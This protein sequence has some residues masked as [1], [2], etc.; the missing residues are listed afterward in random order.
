MVNEE[1][2]GYIRG[3]LAAGRSE[4][5]ITQAL[6]DYGWGQDDIK[7][8]LLQAKGVPAGQ[9]DAMATAQVAQ[10]QPVEAAVA[11][12]PAAAVEPVTQA[13]QVAQVQ[14]AEPVIQQQPVAQAAQAMEQSQP[15]Q[16][17]PQVVQQEQQG[18]P[19]DDDDKKRRMV[20]KGVII[21]ILI[22][23][24]FWLY[25]FLQQE[26]APVVVEEEVVTTEVKKVTKKEVVEEPKA[27]EKEVEK[28]EPLP[29]K[30]SQADIK[31]LTAKDFSGQAPAI[32]PGKVMVD[33]VLKGSEQ[34]RV[35]NIVRNDYTRREIYKV[36]IHG[37]SADY[38]RGD[39]LLILDAGNRVTP[40]EFKILPGEAANGEYQAQIDFHPYIEDSGAIGGGSGNAVLA[41]VAGRIEFSV[42]GEERI[43]FDIKRTKVSNTEVGMGLP[44]EYQVEN[45][46]NVNWRPDAINA[47]VY[48]VRGELAQKISV[49]AEELEFLKPGGVRS[50]KVFMTHSISPGEYTLMVE[51]EFR[52][53]KVAQSEVLPLKVFPQNTIGQKGELVDVILN[54]EVY[55]PGETARVEVEFKNTGEVPVKALA[56]GELWL[57]DSLMDTAR[58]RELVIG[59]GETL[60]LRLTSTFEKKGEYSLDVYVEYGN[61]VSDTMNIMVPVGVKAG[62]SEAT[63]DS[64]VAT[65]VQ[66]TGV[67][68]ALTSAGGIVGVS[69]FVLI[70]IL[71]T[72]M[73]G[74]KK[75]QG[76]QE[77]Q[78][79]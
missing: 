45:T 43:E 22:L 21:L 9:A 78:G 58:G 16:A 68:N 50:E 49:S 5:E 28:A 53:E 20:I 37:G 33:G 60:P 29:E 40:Y 73:Y 10:A 61:K 72:V 3:E 8:G 14:Q 71:I 11:Q 36:K 2:L 4:A 12:Q 35:F 55:K 42:G 31:P 47:Y 15:V 62:S 75:K 57:G 70:L 44:L 23:F 79:Q 39:D 19:S 63:V 69:I 65:E 6:A 67:A 52:G 27:I 46:G 7:S 74:G 66:R 59:V 26:P 64:E 77:G 13:T 54:K 34:T 18:Q 48:D 38:V 32:S 76:Q 56:V 25:T 24:L 30:V 41:G 1:L 51:Y 17:Q